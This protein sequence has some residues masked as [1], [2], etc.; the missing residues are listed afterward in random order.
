VTARACHA[1][2]VIVEFEAALWIW[3]ARQGEKWT[4][5]TLPEDASE[6]I[7]AMTEGVRRG[8]GSVRVRAAIGGSTW[9]TSIFPDSGRKAYVLPVKR[10]IRSAE[11]LETGDTASVT[12]ELIDY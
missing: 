7:R 4:F 5:V 11:H 2:P 8:F 10:A 9:K 12:V 3:D 6:D 1:A